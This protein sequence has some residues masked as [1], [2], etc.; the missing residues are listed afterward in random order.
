MEGFS[1]FLH[2]V[3]SLHQE[4]GMLRQLPFWFDPPMVID[5]K[6]KPKKISPA[7]SDDA[8]DESLLPNSGGATSEPLLVDPS[9][10]RPVENRPTAQSRGRAVEPKT[11]FANE[12][13]FIQWMTAAALLITF[14]AM[15]TNGHTGTI[16]LPIF[17]VASS[18][19]FYALMVY[20]R[21]LRQFQM[22]GQVNYSDHWGPTVLAILLC[23][24]M[25]A[26]LFVASSGSAPDSNVGILPPVVYATQRYARGCLPAPLVV[27]TMHPDSWELQ[28]NF[29]L[30]DFS[31]MDKRRAQVHLLD[32]RIR[33]F[34]E[35]SNISTDW[36]ITVEHWCLPTLFPDCSSH[37]LKYTSEWQQAVLK[38]NNLKTMLVKPQPAP[39]HTGNSK[40]E[41][42]SHCHHWKLSYNL[43][44]NGVPDSSTWSSGTDVINGMLA[45]PFYKKTGAA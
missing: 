24:T 38:F 6:P 19:V 10:S 8:S 35:A 39:G 4:S 25:A 37:F 7:P 9:S 17:L 1:K 27:G 3:A 32:S 41:L 22:T 12:R 11:Y 34:Y 16:A 40:F 29:P 30:A 36:A 26:V 15:A 20:H 18:L 23:F 31:T 42:D 33:R 45:K 14:A 28:Q 5:P 13:T 21:R 2:A 43:A 44:I